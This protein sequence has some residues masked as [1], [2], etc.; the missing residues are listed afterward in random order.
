MKIYVYECKTYLVTET[1]S[2]YRII[3]E[4][5]HG[6]RPVRRPRM[7]WDYSIKNYFKK[8]CKMIDMILAE[9]SITPDQ[10]KAEY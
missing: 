8:I 1:N 4:K 9:L 2:V 7:G 3:M 6:Y 5:Y 10:V